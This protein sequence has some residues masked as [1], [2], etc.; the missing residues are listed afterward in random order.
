[1]QQQRELDKSLGKSILVVG[2][3]NVDHFYQ[4]PSLELYRYLPW[5][6]HAGECVLAKEQQTAFE[7]FLTTSKDIQE[8]RTFGGGQAGNVSVALSECDVH[9]TLFSAVGD[10]PSASIALRDLSRVDLSL[11]H[12]HDKTTEAFIFVDSSGERDILI[13]MSNDQ[14]PTQL[15]SIEG[16]NVD[17]V[18]F[19]S[20]ASDEHLDRQVRIAALLPKSTRQSLDIGSLYS[21]MGY[22][23]V[24]RLIQGLDVL[25]A[26][27]SE[28]E[29]FAERPVVEAVDLF[30]SDGVAAI[31]CKRGAAGA[32]LYE[33]D[34]SVIECSSPEVRAV[35]S[36]GAGDV[37]AGVFVGAC[38]NGATRPEA[39]RVATNLASKS[40]TGWGRSAY[41]ERADFRAVLQTECG[42]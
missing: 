30:I 23:R 40:V 10:D 16:L 32:T 12:C 26:T 4:V 13:S 31:C 38:L 19:T 1:M 6:P 39:L 27:Q 22:Q 25:F 29:E 17:H 28:L 3:I 11:V 15:D 5:W 18:H 24:S 37:F 20:M 36:T 14:L 8:E 7:R 42:L 41:P 9:V 21:A 34:G 35:D 33:S 2:A